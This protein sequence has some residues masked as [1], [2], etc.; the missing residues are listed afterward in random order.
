MT[1]V[2][3]KDTGPIEPEHKEGGCSCWVGWAGQHQAETATQE[4]GQ[5]GQTADPQER[6][7]GQDHHLYL[8]INT[9]SEILLSYCTE[10]LGAVLRDILHILYDI[11]CIKID[12]YC[13]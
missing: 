7:P 12:V 10:T 6:F 8:F 2:K 11:T 9:P 4:D 13:L 3:L 1:E 5:S